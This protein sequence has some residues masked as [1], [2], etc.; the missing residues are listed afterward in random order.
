MTISALESMSARRIDKTQYAD[1]NLP[2]LIV[3]ADS[4]VDEPEDLWAG[5]PANIL[6][7]LPKRRPLKNRPAGGMDSKLRV[8]D[9]D[10]D[11]VAAEVL[12]PSICM[13]YFE[14]DQEV[15]EAVFPVYNDWIADYCQ[16]APDRLF[17][18]AVL[19]V[20]DVDFAIK[21]LH[22]CH[23]MGL[24]GAMIW[25]VPDP[26]LPFTDPNHYERFWAAT[27]EIGAPVN[28]HTL[29]GY[30]YRRTELHGMERARGAVNTSLHDGMTTMFDLIWSGVCDRHPKIRFESVE[31]EIGW[32]PWLLQQWDVYFQRFSATGPHREEFA[33]N[34]PPSEIFTEHFYATFLDDPAGCLALSHWGEKNCMWSSDYPHPSMTWPNSRA[35]ISRQIGHLPMDKKERLLSRNV[36]DLYNL[37]F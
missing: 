13:K 19:P 27:A 3:S 30:N 35:F 37:P 18:I 36:I 32:M 31:A 25:R 16:I 28:L 22:R 6:D 14:L 11:G 4:H 2:D 29:T 20:Y 10:L 7:K 34:R 9:M 33:I 21:E 15:Q 17:G 5:L 24:K 12:Y 23:D 26:K 8:S 1:D